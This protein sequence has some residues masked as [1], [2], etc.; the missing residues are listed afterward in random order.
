MGHTET[1]SNPK[2][3]SVILELESCYSPS[4]RNSYVQEGTVRIQIGQGV[5]MVSVGGAS[6]IGPCYSNCQVLRHRERNRTFSAPFNQ[7][8]L[9][10]TIDCNRQ[11]SNILRRRTRGCRRQTRSSHSR[12]NRSAWDR[13]VDAMENN[14]RRCSPSMVMGSHIR[15]IPS[16]QD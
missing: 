9:V 12:R 15:K 8:A 6:A 14:T 4:P 16:R 2:R 1:A 11:A 13:L 7:L 5:R 3:K 10:P